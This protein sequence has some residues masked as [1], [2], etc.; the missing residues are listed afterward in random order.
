IQVAV[1]GREVEIRAEVAHLRLC[2]L[3]LH[4]HRAPPLT[5]G[6]AHHAVIFPGNHHDTRWR[7]KTG[8]HFALSG[9]H[10]HAID[11]FHRV[12]GHRYLRRYSASGGKRSSGLADIRSLWKPTV[13]SQSESWFSPLRLGFDNSNS[14]F[15]RVLAGHD[16]HSLGRLQAGGG[17]AING[18]YIYALEDLHRVESH[19]VA[20]FWKNHKIKVRGVVGWFVNGVVAVELVSLPR[21]HLL[22]IARHVGGG[23]GHVR[24]GGGKT[25]K[26]EGKDKGYFDMLF[27][28]EDPWETMYGLLS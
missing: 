24:L 28:C 11:Q 10:V 15:S 20:A 9:P 17:G 18:P 19:V 3:P 4:R 2:S 25:E 13:S 8:A 22:G 6:R 23:S 27:Y 12:E 5:V 21:A 16:V 26:G 1:V 7:L 14:Q